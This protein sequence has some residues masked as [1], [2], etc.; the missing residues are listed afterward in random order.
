MEPCSRAKKLK[1][2]E[3][4]Q[5]ERTESICA[6]LA[7]TLEELFSLFQGGKRDSS[8]APAQ[9]LIAMFHAVGAKQIGH[10][11]V[12]QVAQTTQGHAQNVNW[13]MRTI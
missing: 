2:I 8:D 13:F 1:E 5:P 10:L 3:L 4:P 9:Q 11:N 12:V 7:L 6:T